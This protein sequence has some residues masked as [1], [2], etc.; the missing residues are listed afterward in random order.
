[1]SGVAIE[2]G[3]VDVLVFRKAQKGWLVLALQR[4]A[5]TRC[6]GVWEMVHGKVEAGEALEDAAHRELR[7]E[8]GLKAE[9]LI[10]VGMHSFYLVPRPSVQLCAVFAAVVP[11]DGAVVLGEEH[12]RHAWLTPAAARRRFTWPQEQ[13][14]LDDARKLLAT[15]EVWDV[16]ER[17][18]GDG[19]R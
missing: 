12:S 1:V 9:R 8:T 18:A 11:N 4:S 7:E 13:R 19:R 5:Q 17:Q 14:S 10:S 6:P 15:P 2:V 16:L 3:V